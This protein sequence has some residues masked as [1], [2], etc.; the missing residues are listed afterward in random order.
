MQTSATV[1][2]RRTLATGLLVVTLLGWWSSICAAADA[3][4]SPVA[5]V[6][7]S[8]PPPLASPAFTPPISF[9]RGGGPR[10]APSFSEPGAP[11][12]PLMSGAG[13]PD[14]NIPSMPGAPGAQ[15]RAMPPSFDENLNAGA[16]PPP[17][18][19]PRRADPPATSTSF[20]E[21][22]TP[23]VQA[24]DCLLML[25]C[26]V[27]CLRSSSRRNNGP[28]KLMALACFISA[29]I[30]LGF[31]LSSTVHGH[32]VL[33]LPAQLQQGAYLLARILSPFE[34]LLFASAIIL[35]ARRNSLR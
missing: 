29:V 22:V 3:A 23:F 13:I 2:F 7:Q 33:S 28:L 21:S 4:A 18:P 27:Y 9:P 5:Q 1:D 16:R 19:P 31:F 12:M 15:L 24:F 17:S 26:G 6:N 32:S 34:L 11:A 35:I 30:L 14:P 25:F 10:G 8:P 20:W